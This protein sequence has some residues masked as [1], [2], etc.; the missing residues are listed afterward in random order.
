MLEHRQTT[1]HSGADEVIVMNNR[2][3]FHSLIV[4]VFSV[5]AEVIIKHYSFAGNIHVLLSYV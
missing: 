4:N 5:R 3:L 2:I 1:L